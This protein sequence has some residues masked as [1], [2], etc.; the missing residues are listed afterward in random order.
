MNRFELLLSESKSDVLP[1]HYKLIWVSNEN[2]THVSRITTERT[3]RCTINTVCTEG[4][5]RTL[6]P[7]AT[8]SKAAMSTN[9]IT[10]AFDRVSP[11]L[12]WDLLQFVNLRRRIV[13]E[14]RTHD[15]SRPRRVNNHRYHTIF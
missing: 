1:L 3:N 9:S 8:G 12:S 2:R 4:E 6:T 14:I 13:Y 10:S 11:P 15:L 7:M 5:T